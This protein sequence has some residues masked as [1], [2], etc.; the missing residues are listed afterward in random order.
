[1]VILFGL[2]VVSSCLIPARLLMEKWLRSNKARFFSII[3][4]FICSAFAILLVSRIDNFEQ[5]NSKCVLV[6]CIFWVLFE[7]ILCVLNFSKVF[8]Q[9]IQSKK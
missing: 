9:I 5:A 3:L 1:M 8:H 7:S 2:F 4:S 6:A